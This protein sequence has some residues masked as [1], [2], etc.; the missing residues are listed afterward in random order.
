MLVQANFRWK[1]FP[2]TTIKKIER[3]RK[4]ECS[5]CEFD[6]P[7]TT[8]K[9][10]SSQVRRLTI[11]QGHKN[12]IKRYLR[13]KNLAGAGSRVT[14]EEEGGNCQ[15]QASSHPG[16]KNV[17]RAVPVSQ[18]SHHW[19]WFICLSSWGFNCQPQ[20]G[21]DLLCFH[22]FARDTGWWTIWPKNLAI[23]TRGNHLLSNDHHTESQDY[24]IFT[25]PI[26][27]VA[28]Y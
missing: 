6:D 7:Q 13:M 20:S 26:L 1:S 28:T 14:A 3:T 16:W 11:I 19:M 5:P 2:K 12:S 22:L 9:L 25:T 21:R 4:H 18:S 24:S 27:N 23:L 15:E 17:T 8:S 10:S